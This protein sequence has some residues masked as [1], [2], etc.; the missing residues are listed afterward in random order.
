MAIVGVHFVCPQ[1]I[2]LFVYLVA[3]L[4]WVV[5]YIDS[6]VVR[7]GRLNFIGHSHTNAYGGPGGRE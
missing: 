1:G 4:I 5:I 2:F 3:L 6:A 7:L